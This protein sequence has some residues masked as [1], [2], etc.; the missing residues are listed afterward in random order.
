MM[1][2]GN[3]EP[4]QGRVTKRSTTVNNSVINA[5]QAALTRRGR[6]I[7]RLTIRC[8]ERGI[9]ERLLAIGGYL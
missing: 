8:R 7:I 4:L 3:H 5:S 2:D 6:G 1:A 9:D